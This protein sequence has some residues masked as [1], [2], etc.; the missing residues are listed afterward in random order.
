MTD[1]LRDLADGDAIRDLPRRYAHC[2]WQKDVEGIVA[3]FTPDGVMDTGEGRPIAGHEAIRKV[4]KRIF[5][6]NDLMPY[7]HNHVIELDGDMATGHCYLDLQA[8]MEGRRVT[9]AGF[10]LDRYVRTPTG[11][12]FADRK[13]TM[14]R[15]GPQDANP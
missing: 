3:L 1:T 15:L 4:Y 12:K 9:G 8:T 5:E 11:W 14:R 2:V 7:V 6:L 10:Y 13:L